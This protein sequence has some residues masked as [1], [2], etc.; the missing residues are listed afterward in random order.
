MS[1]V[2]ECLLS[3]LPSV[4]VCVFMLICLCVLCVLSVCV[5]CVCTMHACLCNKLCTYMSLPMCQC[6]AMVDGF[7]Q[8]SQVMYSISLPGSLGFC[9]GVCVFW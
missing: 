6:I 5:K 8:D 2:C 4:C 1:L 3:V 9:L 7:F